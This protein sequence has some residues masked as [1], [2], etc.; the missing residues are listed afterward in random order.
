MILS[1]MLELLALVL[2]TAP[3]QRPDKSHMQGCQGVQYKGLPGV[4][5]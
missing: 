5:L 2:S 1:A 3:E 4:L